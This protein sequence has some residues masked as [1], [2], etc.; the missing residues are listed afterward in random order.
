MMITISR[1]KE[2]EED[3]KDDKDKD[4]A[5]GWL[6]EHAFGCPYKLKSKLESP[7]KVN[8]AAE[9]TIYRKLKMGASLDRTGDC[10]EDQD[11]YNLLH[12][13]WLISIDYSFVVMII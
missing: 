9:R 13:S 10:F 5:N 8:A 1:G 11:L 2:M 3:Q 7:P 4:Y 6:R 12:S